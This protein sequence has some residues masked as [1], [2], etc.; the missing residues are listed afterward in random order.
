MEGSEGAEAGNGCGGDVGWGAGSLG[1]VKGSTL[2]GAGG[3]GAEGDDG[4]LR[5][6]DGGGCCLREDSERAEDESQGE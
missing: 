4:L 1:I 2:G 6:G 3:E 5:R